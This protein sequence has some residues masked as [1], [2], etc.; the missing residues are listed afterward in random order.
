MLVQHP[1]DEVRDCIIILSFGA[2]CSQKG[3]L[4]NEDL[5]SP[6]DAEEVVVLR[7]DWNDPVCIF[8][9]QLGQLSVASQ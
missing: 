9:I 5:I 4:I 6:G 1:G 7:I 2:E 3:R 8:V